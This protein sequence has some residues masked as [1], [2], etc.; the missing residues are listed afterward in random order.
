MAGLMQQ[1]GFEA[2]GFGIEQDV[3]LLWKLL[4]LVTVL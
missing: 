2:L 4:D 1:G 3:G